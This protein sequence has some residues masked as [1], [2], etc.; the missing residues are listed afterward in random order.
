MWIVTDEYGRVIG[1]HWGFC[2]P[3]SYQKSRGQ[4]YELVHEY[5]A[6]ARAP[7]RRNM[8]WL[9]SLPVI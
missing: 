9:V 2:P 7:L 5:L 1:K 6:K 4:F 3:R 8:E